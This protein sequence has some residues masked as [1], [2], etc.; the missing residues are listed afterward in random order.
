MNLKATTHFFFNLLGER[1]LICVCFLFQ[2]RLGS[3]WPQYL[4]EAA[5]RRPLWES[6]QLS[7]RHAEGVPLRWGQFIGLTL[8]CSAPV[9]GLTF[10]LSRSYL[11]LTIKWYSQKNGVD[12]YCYT[13][14][15]F[16]CNVTIEQ[17]PEFIT[18]T[19]PLEQPEGHCLAP[20]HNGNVSCLASLRGPNHNI[21]LSKIELC[22]SLLIFHAVIMFWILSEILWMWVVSGS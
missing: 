22:I 17:H 16:P 7:F 14:R 2:I 5:P 11:R 12:F 8:F 15:V 4:A 18:G 1:Q 10:E 20:G 3:C 13:S 6:G 21:C 9:T 19:V